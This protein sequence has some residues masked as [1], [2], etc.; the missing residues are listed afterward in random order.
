RFGKI[1]GRKG[2]F[3]RGLRLCTRRHRHGFAGNV[4][5]AAGN[6]LG[7]GLIREAT[8]AFNLPCIETEGFE[9]DDIIA[10]YA[11][12]AEATGADVTIVSSDKDLMQLV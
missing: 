12:Q 7:L 10:T 9:A 11:R 3:D 1:G 6:G 5:D 2:A 8:R 4:G